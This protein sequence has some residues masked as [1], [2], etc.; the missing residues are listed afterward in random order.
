MKGPPMNDKM[1]SET[2]TQS[3]ALLESRD[4]WRDMAISLAHAL[5]PFAV[6]ACDKPHVGEPSC[7]NC[8]AKKMLAE[9]TTLSAR[10]TLKEK[11]K[12]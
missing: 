6:Y 1:R 4:A 7:N 10:E 2:P 9:F 11:D 5:D 3:S 8:Y 12:P